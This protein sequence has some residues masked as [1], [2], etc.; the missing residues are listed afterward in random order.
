MPAPDQRYLSSDP[1]AGAEPPEAGTSRYLSTDPNAGSAS[2]DAGQP[3]EDR[4]V[5][6]FLGNVVSSG[7]NFVGNALHGASLVGR[8]SQALM[9]GGASALA[10]PELMQLGQ[11]LPGSG[12]RLARGAAEYFGNRYGSLDNAG[13]TL[14]EDPVGM[15]ADASTVLTA[16]GAM[17]ARG[18]GLVGRAGRALSA[19]GTAVDPAAVAARTTGAMARPVA[20]GAESVA[21]LL[22]NVP[23]GARPMA[24]SDLALGGL[25]GM[26]SGD[27]Y[28]AIATTAGSA[29]LRSPLVRHAAATGLRGGAGL[30]TRSS[31]AAQVSPETLT[32]LAVLAQLQGGAP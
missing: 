12:P 15:A 8:A 1:N 17:A 2:P 26:L 21:G 22:D 29:A 28:M 11:S 14:Y 4:S 6:G 5:T 16:G 13:R 27:P 20:R 9:T 3:N 7:A 25:G 32:R 23:A 31:Q 10:D 19:A 18:P 30:L 24:P